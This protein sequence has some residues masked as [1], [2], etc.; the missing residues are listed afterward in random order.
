MKIKRTDQYL[1]QYMLFVAVSLAALFV[2]WL[3]RDIISGDFVNCLIPWYL[4]II[5]AGPGIDALLAY[6]GDYT[7]PYAFLIWLMGKLPVPYLYSL[8]FVSGVFDFILALLA[9]KIVSHYKPENQYSFLLGYSVI[10]FL[11][12]IVLNSCFWGQC[13][14]IYTT[15][16]FAALYCYLLKK[17]PAMMLM[18]GLAFSFKLQTVVFLP[19]VLIMYWLKREFS[20]FNF[21]I[22][23]AVMLITNIPA[24]LA[25]YPPMIA[26]TAYIF[27]TQETPW[28]YYFYPNLWFFFQARPYYLFG[29]GA[30]MLAV[31]A[32]LIFI[33]L[34]VKKKVVIDR[35]SLLPIL[36]WTSY[37]CV[38]FLP[39]MHER[40]G[41]FAEVAA[42]VLALV[43]FHLIWIPVVMI[44]CM[45]PKY[46][47]AVGYAG[48]SLS[49]QMAEAVGNTLL[50]MT[51]T[52][53][54]WR[55]L[56]LERDAKV[57]L[58][59]QELPNEGQQSLFKKGF[60]MTGW[61]NAVIEWL[62]RYMTHIATGFVILVAVWIRIAGRNYVGNDYHFS[63]YDIAGNCN[64]WLYR[65]LAGF[66][67]RNPEGAITA[68]KCLAYAGD[69]AVAFF[70]LALLREKRTEDRLLRTFLALT[71]CLL[72][73]VALIYSV[74]GMEIDS[75]C[76]SL[77]LAAVLLFRKNL[78]PPAALALS[79]AALLYPAYWPVAIA[80][81]ACM[82]FRRKKDGR[83][84]ALT[85]AAVLFVGSLI[86]SIFMEQRGM[87]SGYFWGKI[88]VVN[89]ATGQPYSDFGKW[90][91]G[92]CAIY[93]YLA[94]MGS[95][96]LAFFHKK[97]RIPALLVQLLV[98]MYVGWQQTS[99]LAV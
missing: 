44:L 66:L 38:F 91:S 20:V 93:G 5:G 81:F 64:A 94:A 79:L 11:P 10:L 40:Y 43:N 97:L 49:L 47:Y 57:T 31:T 26:F 55:R 62:N 92:M 70:A 80:L 53:M 88:F 29:S 58:R 76:M 78:L 22:V 89:P 4:E 99:F 86:F 34:L 30:V 32:L 48:N 39:S 63:L 45:L 68:L 2:R 37:T 56:F 83:Y 60:P 42:V 71:A 14:V 54:L 36:F 15:F 33:L 61:E 85:V 74:G 90:L 52:C 13:D 96:M 77:L 95:L 9:G 73:P 8:K 18:L 6:T 67:M 87:D 50:Y 75:V 72:S 65:T 17:Y 7:M 82:A 3:G 12:N 16:L 24:V 21:L 51:C 35:A 25:G 1:I 27:Q 84:I 28:L 69:F 19:F 59:Q 23:P 46:L 98:I 41:Y